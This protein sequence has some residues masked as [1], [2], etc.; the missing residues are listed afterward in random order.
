VGPLC[1]GRRGTLCSVCC[2]HAVVC[3]WSLIR[4]KNS[5]LVVDYLLAERVATEIALPLP[6]AGLNSIC[7]TFSTHTLC[8]SREPSAINIDGSA[9]KK[10]AF[11]PISTTVHLQV[12]FMVFGK[13]QFLKAY[14][15]DQ[16]EAYLNGILSCKTVFKG[17][18][19]GKFF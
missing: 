15:S 7:V 6:L 1:R 13:H 5:G 3:R 14:R 18:K 2:A 16:F 4:E 10:R 11:R 8:A 19:M 17:A 12:V 9:R